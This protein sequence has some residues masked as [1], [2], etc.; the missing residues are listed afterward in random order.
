MDVTIMGWDR[1]RVLAITVGAFEFFSSSAVIAIIL[2]RAGKPL[3][4]SV[5]KEQSQT[6]HGLN[7]SC[8]PDP[9]SF[10]PSLARTPAM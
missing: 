7:L 3:P 8:S 4:N 9:R 5:Y 6:R 1:S 2:S 10:H